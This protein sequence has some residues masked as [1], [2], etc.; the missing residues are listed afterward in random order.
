[1]VGLLIFISCNAPKKIIDQK[2]FKL[3]YNHREKFNQCFYEAMDVDGEVVGI[4]GDSIIWRGNVYKKI[5]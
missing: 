2:I 3:F 1:M 4:E 5:K